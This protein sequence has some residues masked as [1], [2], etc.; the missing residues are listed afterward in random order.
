MSALA[1]GYLSLAFIGLLI[2]S[3]M[4]VAVALA[5]VSLLGVW[6]ITGHFW[7]GM[8]YVMQAA[9]DSIAE[10]TFGVVPLFVL[11]GLAFSESGFGRDMFAGVSQLTRRLPAGL[12]VGTVIA[13]ALFATVTGVSIASAA[14]FS[15]VA[16][17]EMVRSGYNQRLAL[18]IVVGS[19]V[20]GMLIPPSLLMILFAIL[21]DTSIGALF[22]GGVGPGLLLTL[23]YCVYLVGLGYLRPELLNEKARELRIAERKGNALLIIP[24]LLL[25]AC[26]LGGIYGGIFTPTEAGAVG[27]LAALLLA[28]AARRMGLASIWRISVQTGHI[29]AAVCFLIIGATVY[30]GMLSLSGVPTSIVEFATSSG[31]GPVGF[32]FLFSAVVIV[33]GTILDSGSTILVSAPLGYPVALHLGIDPIHF[34]LVTIFGAEVGL[35][36][37]PFGLTAFVVQATMKDE[38]VKLNDVWR[39]SFPFLLVMIVILALIILFP[40][41]VLFL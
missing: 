2:Y 35:L 19:S 25:A 9:S 3:G 22:A 7:L 20:L 27:A 8:T 33:L 32:L 30:S 29:T 26:V 24:S 37:P 23:A 21:T 28:L 39:G 34:G 40:Q 4:H 11:M 12:G 5:V 6:A 31:V 14:V 16:I 15:R 10:Y 36:T 17:P 38:G 41:I 1:I 13:N 18:G